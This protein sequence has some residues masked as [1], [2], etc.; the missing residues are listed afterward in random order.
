MP[1]LLDVRSYR[2]GNVDSDHYLVI[3]RM[4]A[5]ISN[6]KRT[7]GERKRKFCVSKLQEENTARMY[8]ERLEE[9]LKQF[10]CIG[11]ETV[12]EE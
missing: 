2:G 10:P 8:A 9:C 1:D 4:R 5:Q 12:Q 11:G 3:A 7:R 6:I